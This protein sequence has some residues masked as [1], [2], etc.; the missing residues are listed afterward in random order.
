MGMGNMAMGM[1]RG[2]MVPGMPAGMPAGMPGMPGMGGM[3]GM[4]GGMNPLMMAQMSRMNPMMQMQMRQRM[5]MMNNMAQQRQMMMARAG[6]PGGM[7]GVMPG[8][9]AMAGG[10]PGAAAGAAGAVGASVAA[11]AG[12]AAG[13][14]DP[15][16]KVK[17]ELYVGNVPVGSTDDALK[18]FLNGKMA[19]GGPEKRLATSDAP[20]VVNV[21]L[22]AGAGGG[23]SFAFV[24][25]RSIEE[26]NKALE[27][28]KDVAFNG[29][30]LRVGRP[31]NY[32]EMGS[33]ALPGA[34]AGTMNGMGMMG[35]YV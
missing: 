7:P 31:K 8:G 19:E 26:C 34:P 22:S 3:G 30:E 35:M 24:E 11:A 16:T 33:S 23:A 21:W 13:A 25:F 9:M 12:G 6:V 17:R 4:M 2:M 27:S 29:V 1:G 15:A 14:P 20:A 18:E 32:N 5:M 10:M 28:L